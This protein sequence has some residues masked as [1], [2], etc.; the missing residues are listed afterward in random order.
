MRNRKRRTRCDR[1]RPCSECSKR[2][3]DC[4]YTEASAPP[5]QDYYNPISLTP[6][7][8]S[9]L[10]GESSQLYPSHLP[11]HGR[12]KTASPGS[13]QD[14]SMDDLAAQLSIITL[15]RRVSSQSRG[16]PHPLQTQ[17]ESI[18]AKPPNRPPVTFI[19]PEQQFSLD[20]VA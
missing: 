12:G 5:A 1:G 8:A 17:I 3:A 2:H 4:D 7:S 19:Q 16:H 6:A 20:L 11:P 18:V 14:F 13:P 9:Q 15:G 10:M